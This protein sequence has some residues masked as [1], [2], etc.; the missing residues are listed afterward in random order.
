VSTLKYGSGHVTQFAYD[1][2]NRRT[3]E[4]DSVV[5]QKEKVSGTVV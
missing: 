1:W 5:K 4:T 3:S 2:L